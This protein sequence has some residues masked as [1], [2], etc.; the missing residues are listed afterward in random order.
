MHAIEGTVEAWQ[1]SQEFIGIVMLPIIGN[2]AEHYTA[3][4]VACKGKLDLSL[5]V[6]AGS[7]CQMALLVTPFTVLCGWYYDVD[8]TLNFHS[9]NFTVLMLAVFLS[10]CILSNGKS[11]WLEGI[12][13]LVTYFIL[14]LLYF[15]EGPSKDVSVASLP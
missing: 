7:S 1:V 9:F 4:V 11:N 8:M 12:M 10:T 6:A 5:G 15:F 2:A 13:L 14:S 3:I